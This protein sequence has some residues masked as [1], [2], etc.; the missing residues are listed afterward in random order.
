VKGARGPVRRSL[1]L[2]SK[3]VEIFWYKL[4]TKDFS[5]CGI[6]ARK[7]PSCKKPHNPH[8]AAALYGSKTNVNENKIGFRKAPAFSCPILICHFKLC[9]KNE[10]FVQLRSLLHDTVE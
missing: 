1:T 7:N 9:C 5:P 2:K 8:I 3:G 4:F 6:Q 10:A